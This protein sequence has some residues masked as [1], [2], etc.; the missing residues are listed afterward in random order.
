MRP[1]HSHLISSCSFIG[2][3]LGSVVIR[4]ALQDD[5]LLQFKDKLHSYVSLAGPHIGVSFN[6]RLVISLL[7]SYHSCALTYYKSSSLVSGAMWVWKKWAGSKS[8]EQLALS[9]ATE[10]PATF[11][12][13]LSLQESESGVSLLLCVVLNALVSGLSLFSNVMFVGS[14]QDKYV[15]CYSAVVEPL[16]TFQDGNVKSAF[17]QNMIDAIMGHLGR[18]HCAVSRV[19]L[20]L[21][22]TNANSNLSSAHL[23]FIASPMFVRA[24]AHLFAPLFAS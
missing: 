10:V 7:R 18:R 11:L 4:A 13:K 12:Y 5:G 24:F 21:E 9:D 1:E 20:D 16:P 23:A 17:H 2:Y 6:D 22:Q 14:E 15:P 3:S 19:Y 8:M